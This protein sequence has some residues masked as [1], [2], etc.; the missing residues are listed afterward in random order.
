[1]TQLELYNNDTRCLYYKNFYTI[2]NSALDK[3]EC[4]PPFC[5]TLIFAGKAGGLPR[6]GLHSGTLQANLQILN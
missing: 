5:L 6:K 4:L 1:M 3:L 2:I